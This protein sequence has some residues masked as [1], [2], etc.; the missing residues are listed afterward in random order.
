MTTRPRVSADL[1]TIACDFT[2]PLPPQQLWMTPM[3]PTLSA[4]P[5]SRQWVCPWRADRTGIGTLRQPSSTTAPRWQRSLP[6]QWW[7]PM[8]R[9]KYKSTTVSPR[10]ALLT[11]HM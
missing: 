7:N 4:P 11:R 6:Y 1:C 8:A 3:P 9:S 2:L 5:C 10:L